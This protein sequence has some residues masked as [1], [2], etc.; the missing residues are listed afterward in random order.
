MAAKSTILR[1]LTAEETQRLLTWFVES[2]DDGWRPIIES[3]HCGVSG[4]YEPVGTKQLVAK[5]GQLLTEIN[6]VAE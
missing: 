5:A 2:Y 6:G 4:R 1:R 3:H